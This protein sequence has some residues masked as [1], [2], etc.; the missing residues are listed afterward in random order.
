MR[1]Y[2]LALV[3]SLPLG[4]A[5]CGGASD[6]TPAKQPQVTTASTNTAS[7]GPVS[8]APNP[9]FKGLRLNRAQYALTRQ[10]HS[11]GYA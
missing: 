4:L 2:G 3:A 11:R 8:A 6:T 9:A 5:A 1:R 10:K 7:G